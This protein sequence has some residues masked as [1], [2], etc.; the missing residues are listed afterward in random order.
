MFPPFLLQKGEVHYL[1]AI[2]HYQPS[3][4]RSWWSKQLLSE[5]AECPLKCR[6]ADGVL[7]QSIVVGWRAQRCGLVVDNNLDK[8]RCCC[9]P[10]LIKIKL[11][12]KFNNATPHSV[13]N[14][15][16]DLK[17][18]LPKFSLYRTID[19]GKYRKYYTTEHS[20]F[21]STPWET[22]YKGS[23]PETWYTRPPQERV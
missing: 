17:T 7:W 1:L 6:F 19:F 12:P 5:G 10:L 23:L 21:Y 15:F 13:Q 9:L 18:G 4:T 8:A 14:A 20:R 16:S 22:W 2:L 11:D 3:L